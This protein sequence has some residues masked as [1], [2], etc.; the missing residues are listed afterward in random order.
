MLDY[1]T[2]IE[3]QKIINLLD[4]KDE[5]DPR[6]ETRKRYIVNDHNNGK[7]GQ[8]DDVES[9]VKFN[10]EIVKPFLCDYS[11]AYIL[12]TGHIKVQARNGDTRVAIKNCHPFTRAFFR[13]NDEQVDTADNLELTMN[14]Y[15]ILE[16]SDNYTDTTAALYQYKR[17]EPSRNNDGDL[18]DLFAVTSSSFK[19]QSGLVQKQ[20]T[21]DDF[22][23]EQIGP[24]IDPN[25]DRAHR[26]WKNIKIVVPLEYINNFF[27][28]LEF[29][30]INTKI[31]MKL[32][33]PKYSVL[34]NQ[35]KKSIFQIT[36]GELHISV[37]TLNTENNNKLSKLLSKEFERTVVWN[38]YRSK[39]QRINVAQNDNNFKRTTLDTSFQGVN[40]LLAAAYKTDDIERNVNEDNSINRCY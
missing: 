2:K 28:N 16:Y 19:Y 6:F 26:I 23:S 17:P 20:L 10:T 1:F 3:S 29:S 11:D 32:N 36:K 39:I 34:C 15:N 27:R 5:D 31:Y 13:L 35:D 18:V 7:Y 14:L 8:G 25:F 33:W 4:Q 21:T 9:S 30:L 40:K 24:N 12:V 22:E 38:E 37:V